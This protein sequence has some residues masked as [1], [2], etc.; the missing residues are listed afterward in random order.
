[1]IYIV[2]HGQT[3]WN[4]TKRKQGRK[5]SPLTRKGLEQALSVGATLSEE[6][7]H[8]Q[9]FKLVISPQWRCQQFASLICEVLGLDFSN[10][11]LEEDIREHSFGLWEG[12]TEEEIGREFPGFLEKRYKTENYWSYVVPMGESYE[13]LSKRVEVVLEKYQNQDVIFV[14]HEMVSKVMR[15][16]LMNYDNSTT[17]NLRHPQDT[18]F[19]YKKDNL[20][21]IKVK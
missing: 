4:K 17:L 9:N 7:K 16:L 10:C 8:P 13:L 5:D 6:M 19:K 18:I 20:E 3:Q 15:G 14:C 2:R 12:K 21:E 11:I 1:M